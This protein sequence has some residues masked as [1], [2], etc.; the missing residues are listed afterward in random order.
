MSKKKIISENISIPESDSVYKDNTTEQEKKIVSALHQEFDSK[1][2][3][4]PPLSQQEQE[5]LTYLAVLA[6]YNIAKRKRTNYRKYGAVAIVV[7]GVAFLALIFSLEAKIEFLCLWIVTILGCVAVMIRAEYTYH[8]FKVMLG[9]ADE[10][11]YYGMDEDDD[12]EEAPPVRQKKNT[13]A[14][15]APA[16]VQPAPDNSQQQIQN[17]FTPAAPAPVSSFDDKG[18]KTETEENK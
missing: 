6:E 12:E 3:D 2:S 4:I 14:A 1:N 5:H 17:S 11:D 9:I 13:A 18:N 7:S 10:Y 16:P 15:A 8:R